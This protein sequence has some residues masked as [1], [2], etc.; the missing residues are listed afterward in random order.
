M[1]DRILSR[2]EKLK[3]LNFRFLFEIFFTFFKIS[4]FTFGGGFSMIPILETEM[5]QKKKWIESEKITD[6]FAVSQTVP[7][8]IAVNSATFIGYQL[9]GVP[10]AVAAAFGIVTPT[11]IIIILL[12]IVL[13]SCQNN[14]YVQ[15]AFKGIRPVVVSLIAIAAVKMGKSS[16][17]DKTSWAV[18]ILATISL[19]IFKKINLVFFIIAGAFAGIVIFKFRNL[20]KEAGEKA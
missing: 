4:P 18:C 19:F 11:F 5:V 13:V 7:G 9:A 10:G 1:L 20:I 12:S 14:S 6:M 8:A 15:A 16:L 2:I 17:K 3:K